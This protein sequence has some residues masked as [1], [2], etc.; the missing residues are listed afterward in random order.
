MKIL[1]ANDQSIV[2]KIGGYRRYIEAKLY[3]RWSEMPPMNFWRVERDAKPLQA[4]VMRSNWAV[5]C[6]VC[7]DI[8]VAEPGEPFHCPNCNAAAR[9]VTF[10]KNRTA[11]EAELLKRPDPLTRAWLPGETV[12][13]LK[14]Q[15][16]EHGI[17]E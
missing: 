8:F 17:E 7:N 11:I 10:P 13:D 12:D 14:R 9:P 15:N 2:K 3:E 16:A 6:D 5:R 4:V 1:T